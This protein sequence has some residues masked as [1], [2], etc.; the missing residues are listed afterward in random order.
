MLHA[1]EL[2]EPLDLAAQL[3]EELTGGGRH[4]LPAS[5]IQLPQAG[6]CC[7]RPAALLPGLHVDI[8]PQERLHQTT[9]TSWQRCKSR[10][11]Y[12][13]PKQVQGKLGAFHASHR[14]QGDSA[15]DIADAPN[16]VN[17]HASTSVVHLQDT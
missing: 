13:P 1:L 15:G 8:I 16:A 11:H 14:R 5:N 9:S 6:T 12:A 17:A 2:K 3:D 4:G 7:T 10:C